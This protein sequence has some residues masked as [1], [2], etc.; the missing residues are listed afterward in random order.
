MDVIIV[1][2]WY[3]RWMLLEHPGYFPMILL[4]D[5]DATED[6]AVS[7]LHFFKPETACVRRPKASSLFDHSM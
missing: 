2:A 7:K 6:Y 4:D 3:I 5:D 1:D